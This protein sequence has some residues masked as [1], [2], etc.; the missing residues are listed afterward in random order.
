MTTICNVKVAYIR[1]KY[2]NLKEWM[3]DPNN[4][5]IGRRGIVFI[6]KERYPNTDS[7]W[8][9]PYRVKADGRKLCLS[10]YETYIRKQLTAPDLLHELKSLKGKTLGCWC[11]PEPCHGDILIKLINEYFGADSVAGVSKVK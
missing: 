9:N 8:A 1:P 3:Q 11:K 5:Y 10:Q 4:A 2:Q 6:D 7:V